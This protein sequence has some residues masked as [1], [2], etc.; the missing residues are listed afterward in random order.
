MIESSV[1]CQY[2]SG[3][4]DCI[5]LFFPV[6]PSVFH[7]SIK[8]KLTFVKFVLRM[9]TVHDINNEKSFIVL[10]WGTGCYSSSFPAQRSEIRFMPYQA[11]HVSVELK[12]DNP[13]QPI[14]VCG[15]FLQYAYKKKNIL[16]KLHPR[17][18][19]D[20]DNPGLHTYFLYG[21]HAAMNCNLLASIFLPLTRRSTM[22]SLIIPKASVVL[23]SSK[24]NTVSMPKCSFS[25]AVSSACSTFFLMS[26]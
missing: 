11:N 14:L 19:S 22:T 8:F 5:A 21:L 3:R 1:K 13:G 2:S 16:I 12:H 23:A 20:C 26:S 6:E 10:F 15:S 9:Y 7:V 4:G 24:N 18:C 17:F 25:L